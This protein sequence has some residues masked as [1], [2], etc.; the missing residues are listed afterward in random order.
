MSHITS[1]LKLL[2]LLLLLPL[3][4]VVGW[5]CY[6]ISCRWATFIAGTRQRKKSMLRFMVPRGRRAEHTE[7]P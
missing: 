3:C 5:W 1:R 4:V 7:P 2:L 6:R